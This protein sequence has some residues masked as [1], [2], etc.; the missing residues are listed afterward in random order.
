MTATHR[1]HVMQTLKPSSTLWTS[2]TFQQQIAAADCGI[3]LPQKLPEPQQ[4]MTKPQFST[5]N[6]EVLAQDGSLLQSSY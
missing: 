4:L 2:I 5:T 6:R 1:K 3:G